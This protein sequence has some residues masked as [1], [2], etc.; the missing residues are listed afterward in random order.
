MSARRLSPYAVDRVIA[1]VVRVQANDRVL[2]QA[3]RALSV[4][5]AD[6]YEE[7]ASLLDRDLPNA[8]VNANEWRS[9][10]QQLGPVIAEVH[11]TDGDA[12]VEL[13][14]AWLGRR[15]VIERKEHNAA[16]D[17]SRP[18]SRPRR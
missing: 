3:R 4:L 9:F 11:R 5:R 17:Q 15:S 14:L 18:G 10:R 12:G 13:F 8:M 7:L 1:K 16:R 6:G 2:Q